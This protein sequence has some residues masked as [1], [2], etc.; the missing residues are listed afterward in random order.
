MTEEDFLII[1]KSIDDL[2]ERTRRNNN[3]SK[4]NKHV[5]AGL[6]YIYPVPK[7]SKAIWIVYYF[8]ITYRKNSITSF[9][10][11]L[12]KIEQNMASRIKTTDYKKIETDV[13]SKDLKSLINNL[14]PGIWEQKLDALVK[15]EIREALKTLKEIN[16]LHLVPQKRKNMNRF[17]E[18][19]EILRLIKLYN[20]KMFFYITYLYKIREYLIKNKKYIDTL[21]I[22]FNKYIK[23]F[24][25][26]V[27]L[28]SK[29]KEKLEVSSVIKEMSELAG[30]SIDKLY[31]QIQNKL[32]YVGNFKHPDYWNEKLLLFNKYSSQAVKK[33]IMVGGEFMILAG[34][35]GITLS[36]LVSALIGVGVYIRKEMK[37]KKSKIDPYAQVLSLS[38]NN[39]NRNK[40]YK[41]LSSLFSGTTETILKPFI[42]ARNNKT[43]Y[44]IDAFS[45][46][47]NDNLSKYNIPHFTEVDGKVIYNNFNPIFEIYNPKTKNKTSPYL[48]QL[49]S[50]SKNF[51]TI[52]SDIQNHQYFTDTIQNIQKVEGLIVGDLSKKATEQALENKLIPFYEITDEQLQNPIN[53]RKWVY[54]ILMTDKVLTNKNYLGLKHE[55]SKYIVPYLINKDI[56][57]QGKEYY[58]KK[59]GAKN[60][61][62]EKPGV[63]TQRTLGHSFM[64]ELLLKH[65]SSP[66]KSKSIELNY[67]TV[68]VVDKKFISRYDIQ[69]I[70]MGNLN[71]D[72]IL[73]EILISKNKVF[74]V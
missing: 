38:T 42:I 21:Q 26:F 10:E 56:F 9:G 37:N 36:V 16:R 15:E 62:I 1:L 18:Y 4:N 22:V 49:L 27:D 59:L 2:D 12:L 5:F 53:M 69:K 58:Q 41:N 54:D 19:Y 47:S 8:Y 61:N 60:K 29:T 64:R 25:Y 48:F 35:I 44:L 70:M 39:N 45:V 31:N 20:L 33:D 30:L 73:H 72:D 34:T 6:P 7:I 32:V 3:N 13:K 24:K 52:V 68:S 67:Q 11:K 23:T 50:G 51:Y 66:I 17:K 14:A 71:V 55:T 43:I 46:C 57:K 28:M 40:I 63:L 74:N 65:Y